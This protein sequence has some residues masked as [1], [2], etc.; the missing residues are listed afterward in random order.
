ML[1]KFNIFLITIF[2]L[3]I[4]SGQTTF[5]SLHSYDYWRF[6]QF[7][8]FSCVAL[9]FFFLKKNLDIPK[10]KIIFILSIIICM[11]ST[12][13]SI[14]P[15]LSML[16][17]IWNILFFTSLYILALQSSLDRDLAK[18]ATKIISLTPLMSIG[19]LP[20]AVI[21]QIQGVNVNWHQTF[22]NYRMLDDAVLPC[23]FFLWYWQYNTSNKKLRILI[24][25][26]TTLYVLSFLLDGARAN[27]LAILIALISIVFLYKDKF[28][29]VVAPF[30]TLIV[31]IFIYIFISFNGITKVGSSLNRYSSSGRIDLWEKALAVWLDNPVLGVG[32]ANF[33]NNP[34][35]LFYAHPHNLILQW[36]AEWGIVGVLLTVGLCILSYKIICMRRTIPPFI[37]GF[38]IAFLVNV[39]LSGTMIY[40]LSQTLNLWGLA[41]IVSYLLKENH[42]LIN[43]KTLS[44]GMG[45]LL[46]SF[47]WIVIYMVMTQRIEISE[48]ERF[49]P[50]LWLDGT[51]PFLSN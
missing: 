30:I 22:P 3:I 36:L 12:L 19:F 26:P 28:R 16:D 24:Y 7:L 27:L 13:Q 14:Q 2:S 38:F 39:L 41:L 50:R 15:L 37:L 20:L 34:P 46:L 40:P 11:F 35:M 17:L 23:L 44:I 51:T 42:L 18:Q 4:F 1:L 47:M 48:A 43:Q 10:I 5:L 29:L 49:A 31:A 6:L 45:V 8:L 9:Q 25:I 21:S 33:V 32:G